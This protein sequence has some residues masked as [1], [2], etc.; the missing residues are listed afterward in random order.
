MGA[1]S[2]KFWQLLTKENGIQNKVNTF[3]KIKKKNLYVEI[4]YLI[5][6]KGK[7]MQMGDSRSEKYLKPPLLDE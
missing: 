1:T 7:M 4:T 3:D 5:E 2:S 6:R